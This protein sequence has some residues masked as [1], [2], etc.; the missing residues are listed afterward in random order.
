ME[1]EEIE[2][3]AYK[4]EDLGEYATLPEKYT[5]LR[6][7]ELYKKYDYGNLTKEQCI[8]EKN[9]IRREYNGYKSEEEISLN[10]CKKYNINRQIIETRLYELEKTKDKN[11]A[12]MLLLDIASKLLN[13]DSFMDR[14]LSKIETN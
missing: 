13:D 6:M 9:N 3:K 1:F 5:Y 11:Y 10:I 4:K 12:L 8:E 14:I 2:K 7:R